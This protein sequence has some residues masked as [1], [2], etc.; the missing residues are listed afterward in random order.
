[1]LKRQGRK[2][3][4]V[5]ESVIYLR[6]LPPG[7]GRAALVCQYIWSCRPCLRTRPASLT[8]V[9]GSCPTFSPLPAERPKRGDGTLQRRLFSVTDGIRLLPSALSAAGRPALSGLSSPLPARQIAL[10]SYVGAKVVKKTAKKRNLRLSPLNFAGNIANF[11]IQLD[12]K[13]AL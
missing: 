6:N 9:V 4:S 1:M 10:P 5:F 12:K 8:A 7:I 11:A 3:V 13:I 2:P